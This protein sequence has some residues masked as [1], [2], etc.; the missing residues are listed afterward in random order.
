MRLR[1]KGGKPHAMPCHHSLET[2]LTAYIEGAGLA[3]D[4]K[5]PLFRTI[6][7]GKGRPLTRRSLP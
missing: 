6:G 3:A 4:S 1:E 2:H 5:G 7:R